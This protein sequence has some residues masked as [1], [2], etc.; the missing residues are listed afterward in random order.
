MKALGRALRNEQ[1]RTVF[2]GWQEGSSRRRNDARE[3]RGREQPPLAR[4][5]QQRRLQ[6]LERAHLDLPDALAAD[7]IDLAQFLE[8]LGLVGEA[9]LHQD[10]LLTIVEAFERG[11][12]QVM[13]DLAFLILG[14]QFVL[15]RAA[16]DEEVLPL[17]LAALIALQGHVEAGV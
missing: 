17:V 9:A 10:M 11:H 2:R 4:E 13:A 14:D 1:R 16:V 6:L 8:R 12:Q 5:A 3:S 15:Q 7:A